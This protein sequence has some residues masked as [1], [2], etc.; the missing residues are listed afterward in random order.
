MLQCSAK[1]AVLPT[2]LGCHR[3][4]S[5]QRTCRRQQQL[6]TQQTR[7]QTVRAAIELDWSDPDTL[8]GLAAAVLG[9]A[10][11]I[12]APLFYSRRDDIDEQRL[13]ELRELNRQTYKETGQYL[14][15]VSLLCL[16]Q[17][18]SS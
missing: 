1:T 17:L 8:T 4:T 18:N 7:Q 3:V 12:G 16:L 6:R 13:E 14:T 10:V 11:G 9:I 5:A 2:Y 15:E